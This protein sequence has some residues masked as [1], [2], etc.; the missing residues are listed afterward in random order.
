[1][2]A[3]DRQVIQFLYC[4]ARTA[5]AG[6]N[7]LYDNCCRRFAGS[8]SGHSFSP[9]ATSR[10]SSRIIQQALQPA[11]PVIQALA[12]LVFTS[13]VCAAQVSKDPKQIDMGRVTF[14]LFCSPCH[15]MHATGGRGPDLT[16][17]TYENGDSDNDLFRVISHG[18]PGSQMPSFAS[19]LTPDNIWQIVSFIRSITQPPSETPVKGDSAAGEQ[20]F[21]GKGG[22][23]QCHMVGS[24]GG[25]LGPDLTKIGRERSL[26]YLRRAIVSPDT[27]LTPGYGT[28]TV[29]TRDGHTITG[30][31]R[32][33]DDFS[34]ELM[35]ASEKLYSFHRNELTSA[36]LE[37]RSLMPSTYGQLFSQTELDNLM[38]YLVSLRG[39]PL[40]TP[41]PPID[42]RTLGDAQLLNAQDN[43]SAWLMYGRNYAGWR[44]SPLAQINDS[45]IAALRPQW[46]FQ[47]AGATE[48]GRMET[49][50]L[51]DNG[52]MW[53]T[54]SSNH[55][56]AVDLRSGREL[57]HYHESSPP[58]LQLC[59]GEEN[60]G[61]A[62]LG[63]RL[64]KVNI[65][66]DLVALDAL[67]GRVVWKTN[68][69]DYKQG[70]SATAAPLIVKNMVLVGSAGADFGVRGFVDAYD[71]RTGNRLWRFYAVPK[72]GE[73]GSE[74]WP[75]MTAWEHGGGATWVTGTYDPELNLVYWGTGNPGPDMDGSVRL[76]DNLYTCSL[77]ALDPDTGKLK[78]YF[79]F[80]PHDV[81]DYDSVQVPVLA[82]MEWKGRNRKIMLW[83]NRN[84]FYYALDRTTGEFLNGKPFAT[85]TWAKG[86]DERGRPMRIAANNPE[87][88]AQRIYPG[89]LG[90][91]NWYSPSYSPRTG[92][93]YIPAWDN[94]HTDF[95]E[96]PAEYREGKN[97]T[98]GILKNSGTGIRGAQ[99]VDRKDEDGYGVVRA[100]DEKTG[101]RKWEFKMV[102]LTMSGVL[103]T[104]SDLL[105]TGSREGYF[106]ALDARNGTLLWKVS[107]GGDIAM[108]PM[109]Y[110]VNGKQ[111]VA[112]TAGSSLFAFGLRP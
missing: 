98:G 21:W 6:L 46:I 80:T 92:L 23:G 16:R 30:V 81:Y 31:E 34:V 82:D 36:K 33:F 59:C 108:G 69:S 72:P 78:W 73:P 26:A 17:G 42:T 110:Q 35:D 89:P 86:L 7:D 83:A 58:N 29:V 102:D 95:Q 12:L 47:A 61:F 62:I 57:W 52:I 66:G 11:R 28:A 15:G 60:R 20:L 38:A 111:Y 40:N 14:R 49:T 68:M 77:V 19:E 107:A 50:P 32:R 5:R 85:V 10:N 106:S 87:S 71:T 96:A 103:T 41:P 51:V 39:G 43:P 65:Q 4:A 70:Y 54:G 3:F 37:T 112:F 74:T 45:N 64:F 9:A 97:F 76:G 109:T 67:T 25:R 101:E 84:G 18:V 79:Q 44:Y 90:A 48:A 24:R 88:N 105:F 55:A 8:A 2:N 22:C 94:T 100:I 56:Y 13:V 91:T 104:A 1:M 75:G 27:D 53:L 93:F 63:N 99:V